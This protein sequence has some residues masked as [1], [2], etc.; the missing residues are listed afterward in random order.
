M[1]TALWCADAHPVATLQAGMLAGGGLSAGT[2]SAVEILVFQ[3]LILL[4]GPIVIQ[5]GIIVGI[6]A[7]VF[8]T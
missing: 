7:S 4:L 5:R 3:V 1:L 6:F 8:P 2:V